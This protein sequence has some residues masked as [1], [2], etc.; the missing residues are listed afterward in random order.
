MQ[1]KNLLRGLPSVCHGGGGGASGDSGIVVV[2][3]VLQ[4]S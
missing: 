3:A 4:S 2:V 1:K